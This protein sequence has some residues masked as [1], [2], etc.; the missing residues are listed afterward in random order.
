MVI[1][2][3]KYLAHYGVA[4]G[5]G[6]PGR[7]SGRYPKGSG[8]RPNQHSGISFKERHTKN[9]MYRHLAADKK[10]VKQYSDTVNEHQSA[11]DAANKEYSRV[12]STPMFN[13]KKK[14]QMLQDA[15]DTIDTMTRQAL[16]H[17]ADLERAKSIYAEDLAK[18][19]S[20]INDV[21]AKYGNTRIKDIQFVYDKK[22]G[23][24]FAKTGVTLSNLPIF[25]TMYS[26][27]YTA[28][29]EAE[30]R[31][32]ETTQRAKSGNYD[33][34]R[35]GVSESEMSEARSKGYAEG[36]AKE[37]AKQLGYMEEKEKQ[38]RKKN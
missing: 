34:S 23:M 4:A 31:A 14:A 28:K 35:R 36:A 20:F 21:N 2:P 7:G 9:T 24:S 29:R 3:E 22:S 12:A 17:I 30:K 26:G 10:L 6:A 8:E 37:I 13:K 15:S 5:N 38:H 25:G 33:T 19:Q 27:N 11:I 1:Q 18:A 16:P 32:E